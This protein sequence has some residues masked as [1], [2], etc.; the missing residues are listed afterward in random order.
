ML[1]LLFDKATFEYRRSE[2]AKGIE[3]DRD[4]IVFFNAP[5][6]VRSYD[7]Q[8]SYHPDPNFSYLTGYREASSAFVM[9]KQSKGQKTV[10]H[11]HLFVMPRDP[12]KEQW[13]GFRYGPEG[14][15][16]LTGATGTHENSF[17]ALFIL[18]WLDA[19]PKGKA[20]RILTNA[21]LHSETQRELEGIVEKF[22]P[23]MRQGKLPIEAWID[24]CPKVYAQRLIKDAGEIKL[25]REAS[26]INVEAHLKG[27]AQ[28]AAGRMEYEVEAAIEG[29]YLRQGC[30]G[31]AYESIVASGANATCLHY[32]ENRRA[33]KQGELL[34]VDAGC[35]YEGYASDITRT[36][37]VG[38]KYT[39]AQRRIMDVVGEAH[40]EVILMSKVGVPYTA[41]HH[42]AEQVLI[43]GLKSLK[44][45]SGSEEKIRE[46][47]A[48]RKYYPHGT[49]HWLGMDVHD[50]NPY[51][52][53]DS[54]PIK[55]GPGMVFTVEPGLYFLKDDDS[56]PREYRGIGVRIEDDILITKNG[57]EILTDGLPRYA[58]E[59]ESYLGT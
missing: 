4:L 9:W 52:D 45:L 27:L 57:T 37:P 41:L 34:L 17:L 14:A 13:E 26:R 21:R 30:T 44:L 6:K 7:R 55:L 43:A 38:K 40:A 12:L 47:A 56:V 8:F 50:P 46:K 2:L 32:N 58:E 33:M 53:A 42:R 16:K 48:H 54:N 3:A 51:N 39:R 15:K 19:V 1:P 22:Q 5:T 10:V 18:Q 24:L 59:I 11:F 49:G 29:E 23:L 36:W 35:E 20:P 31:P 25:L 28:V